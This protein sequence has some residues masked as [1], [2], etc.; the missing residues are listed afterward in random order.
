MSG[1][2]DPRSRASRLEV[3]ARA[4]R[5]R[6]NSPVGG[7]LDGSNRRGENPADFGSRE[8]KIP[9]RPRSFPDALTHRAARPPERRFGRSRRTS[10]AKR[11]HLSRSSSEAVLS[12]IRAPHHTR[13]LAHTRARFPLIIAVCTD[14]APP[15]PSR[16]LLPLASF[17]RSRRRRPPR[18]D[19]ARPPLRLVV[20]RRGVV[21]VGPGS[22]LL[23][24]RL[25]A[26]E[27]LGRLLE[28]LL[29]L[30]LALHR[31]RELFPRLLASASATS[32][33]LSA[34]SMPWFFCDG[35]FAPPSPPP[36][37]PPR[38]AAPSPAP[39]SDPPPPSSPPPSRTRASSAASP[40]AERRPSGPSPSAPAGGVERDG[41][42]GVRRRHPRAQRCLRPLR[43]AVRPGQLIL[44]RLDPFAQFG[45]G[46]R[47]F[48]L[49]RRHLRLVRRLG[50]RGGLS[51]RRDLRLR[52]LLRLRRRRG[53][54]PPPPS[55]APP[56]RSASRAD[57]PPP[58]RPP[59]ASSRSPRRRCPRRRS[60]TWRRRVA[61]PPSPL[62]RA[63]PRASPPARSTAAFLASDSASAS[64]AA[65]ATSA[66]WRFASSTCAVRSCLIA[67]CAFAASLIFRSFSATTARSASRADASFT[68]NSFASDSA[69]ASAV[70]ASASCALTSSISAW[71]GAIAR[72]T[73]TCA[74]VC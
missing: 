45:R 19:G 28:H 68:S 49:D 16:S 48:L 11:S 4:D 14:R 46:P 74:G 52:R 10:R 58:R 18:A 26:L 1:A 30:R 9:R 35:F 56:R 51:E 6:A 64:V 7:A 22:L 63:S 23:E 72:A 59:G 65:F 40:R 44:Q 42:F 3:C 43:L 17:A 54:P 15:F 13:S 25:G 60:R 27:L 55:R 2:R 21:S 20:F 61:S 33:S 57:P 12:C 37:P 73:T 41:G 5:P 67:A 29:D 50:V 66:A 8:K 36:S 32:A 31:R 24:L 53:A 62:A 47:A 70:F 39:P 69:T 38:S 71:Y 34:L